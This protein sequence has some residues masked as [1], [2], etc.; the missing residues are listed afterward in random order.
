M[1]LNIALYMSLNCYQFFVDTFLDCP[2][3]AKA[4]FSTK[5]WSTGEEIVEWDNDPSNGFSVF[6]DLPTDYV[7]YKETKVDVYDSDGNWLGGDGLDFN[8][9][10]IPIISPDA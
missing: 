1:T 2:S 4:R 7:L 10:L 6:F 9:L 8:V 5:V 3:A